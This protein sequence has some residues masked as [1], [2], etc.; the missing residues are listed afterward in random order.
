MPVDFSVFNIY[1]SH[2]GSAFNRY[3]PDGLISWY[4]GLGSD[5]TP[6]VWVNTGEVAFGAP[7]GWLSLHP[8]PAEQP[9][10]IRWTA[11]D[12]GNI[13]VLGEF[14]PGDSGKMVVAIRQNNREIWTASDSGSFDQLV[15][16]IVGD[17]LDFAVYGG[18]W[19][20]NTPVG[21]TISYTD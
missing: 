14:L 12:A 19:S 1:N 18:Y 2:A 17:T 20:G 3:A 16:V 5:R 9:S 15:K 10:V 21:L 13:Q 11:P 7:S 4:E 6:C 8:G